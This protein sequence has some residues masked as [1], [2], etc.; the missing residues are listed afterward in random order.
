MKNRNISIVLIAV[1]GFVYSGAI[2]AYDG[3]SVGKI[4]KIRYQSHRILVNQVNALNPGSCD[5]TGYLYLSQGDSTFLKNVNA[6]L[7]TA[8]AANR[9][10]SLAL[11]GCSSGGTVGYPVISE[12]WVH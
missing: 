5:N 12:V 2:F 11:N 9:P 4:S 8:Y 10:V 6:A 7:L 1:V 3:W